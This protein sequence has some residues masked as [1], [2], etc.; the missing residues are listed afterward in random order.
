MTFTMSK[1]QDLRQKRAGTST[2]IR[3]VFSSSFKDFSQIRGFSIQ[4]PVRYLNSFDNLIFQDSDMY[5]SGGR[6]SGCKLEL[7][8]LLI[9]WT[10]ECQEVVNGN[11]FVGCRLVQ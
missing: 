7:K 11:K 1:R 6:V 2:N 9:C 3:P 5:M 8:A 10:L 4:E